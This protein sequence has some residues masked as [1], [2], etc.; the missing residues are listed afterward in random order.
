MTLILSNAYCD[1]RPDV[2]SVD[3]AEEVSDVRNEENFEE[4]FATAA[5]QAK[6]NVITAQISRYKMFSFKCF[7]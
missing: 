5:P 2:E 3:N 7:I 6:N 4:E 1:N